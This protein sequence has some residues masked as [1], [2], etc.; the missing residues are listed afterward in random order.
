MRHY[1]LIYLPVALLLTMAISRP[2]GA[3]TKDTIATEI[4]MSEWGSHTSLTLNMGTG[5]Y[6]ITAFPDAFARTNP[7]ASEQGRLGQSELRKI[8]LLYRNALTHGL[9]DL[10]CDRDPRS[11]RL[12]NGNAAVPR[13]TIKQ[14]GRAYH[15]AL[16]F[17]CWTPAARALNRQI[18]DSFHSVTVR[19]HRI[20]NGGGVTD[21]TSSTAIPPGVVAFVHEHN[22]TRYSVALLDLNGDDR[23]EALIYAMATAGSGSDADLCGSG[24]CNLY[25][26]SLTQTG[27]GLM[28]AISITRPPIRV[29]PT[30]THGWHDLGVLVAGGGIIPG[31]EARLRF[32]GRTYPSNPTVSPAVRLRGVAGKQVIGELPPV[33]SK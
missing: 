30:L 24:G 18:E 11:N 23:P 17:Q 2:A 28:T 16:S 26:L 32:D 14:G 19:L 1:G 7:P 4:D 25:V 33:V 15:A 27:Y 8:R 13:M 20:A 21:S 10:P 6:T 9:I 12:V 29:L 5:A 3:A 22:L 31:Y